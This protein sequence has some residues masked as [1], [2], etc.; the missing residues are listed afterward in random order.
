MRPIVRAWLMGTTF[1]L[2][3][4]TTEFFIGADTDAA[5]T[6]GETDP[7]T[8][9]SGTTSTADTKEPTTES[10]PTDTEPNPATTTAG[11]DTTTGPDTGTTASPPDTE[12]GSDT[13]TGTSAGT[14][15]ATTDGSGS[16]TS[17]VVTCGRLGFEDCEADPE[18]LWLGEPDTGACE[19][20]PCE[21]AAHDECLKLDFEMCEQEASCEYVGEPDLGDCVLD[22]CAPCEQQGMEVCMES[23]LCE[24][25][26]GEMVCVG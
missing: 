24:W 10:E 21:T 4:C 16:T 15:D 23:P 17:V 19:T 3:G 26:E 14:T 11:P 7:V 12:T 13:T 22:V 18:C 20:N 1:V 8:G 9:L 2:A 25:D 6:E 5:M